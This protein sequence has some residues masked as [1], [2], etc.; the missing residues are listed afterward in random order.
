[1]MAGWELEPLQRELARLAVP[2]LLLVGMQD[3][4]VAP[5]EADRVQRIL[6]GA[7]RVQLPGLGHLAHE[8]DAEAVAA[9]IA[10][11]AAG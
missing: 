2:L 6:P 7:R 1:M 9:A 11:F 3:G 4:T 5:T 10:E 8:E